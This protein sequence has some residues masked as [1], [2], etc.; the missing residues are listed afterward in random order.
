M[1]DQSFSAEN[2][3]KI[4]DYENRKGLYL[5]GKFF[6]EVA[7]KAER[8]KKLNSEIRENKKKL[9]QKDFAYFCKKQ[10]EIKTTLK[11]EEEKILVEKLSEVGKRVVDA[12]FSIEIKK[13]GPVKG[14]DIY[15]INDSLP[16]AYLA[17]KQLQHNISRLYKV[18]QSNRN[19]IVNQVACVLSDGFPKY[20]IRTD[21]QDFYESIPHKKLVEIINRDNLL[22]FMSKKFLRQILNDYKKLSGTSKGIPRGIGVSAYLA[23]I[24]MRDVDRLIRTHSNL[25]Y[26]ARY[27]DDIIIVFTPTSTSEVKD[28]LEEIRERI[29]RAYDL[30]LSIAKTQAIDLRNQDKRY[31][32]EYLGY[33]MSF[34]GEKNQIEIHLTKK[35]KLKYIL[36]VRRSLEDYN[37]VKKYDVKKASKL[38]IKRIRFLT[39]NTRLLNNKRNI[40]VG[41]YYSNPLLT[42]SRDID[43]LDRYLRRAMIFFNLPIE[44][45]ERIKSKYSFRKSYDAK[46][47]SPFKAHE[48]PAIVEAWKNL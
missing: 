33:N 14:K 23:E 8:I 26:Y 28:Y 39:G 42:H 6:P 19:A 21:I 25:S 22:A 45:R 2:F 12:K 32:L 31:V 10:N 16:E 18:K 44:L 15:T 3:R 34:G 48:F 1:L 20:I 29:K 7:E 4:I 9:D 30:D 38:L 43:V 24:Y 17:M 36:R 13:A 37:R 27:V 11:E 5:P 35:K 46:R 41:I 47:F 40:L